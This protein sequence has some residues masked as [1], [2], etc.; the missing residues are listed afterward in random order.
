MVFL[1]NRITPIPRVMP[2]TETEIPSRQTLIVFG[3]PLP[4]WYV[5]CN[6]MLS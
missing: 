1:G 4:G 5:N 3:S 2:Q 6:E